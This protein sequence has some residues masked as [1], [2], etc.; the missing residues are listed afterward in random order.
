MSRSK[1]AAILYRDDES[2]DHLSANKVAVELIQLRQPKLV[3]GVV[4]V[5]RIVWVAAQ[6]V[7]YCIS[8][9]ARLNSALYEL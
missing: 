7:R 1:A 8:T 4:R 9:N 3:A 2:L 5:L 6:V